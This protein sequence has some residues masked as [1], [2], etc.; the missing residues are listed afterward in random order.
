LA[1]LISHENT[2]VVIAVIEVLEEWTDEEVLDGEV[3]EEEDEDEV[4]QS[5]DRE[6]R[7]QAM[8]GLVAGLLQCGVIESSVGSLERFDEADE[9]ERGGVYHTLGEWYLLL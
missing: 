1:D 9:T 8:R 6:E 5:G 2:E 3:E 4:L 7:R